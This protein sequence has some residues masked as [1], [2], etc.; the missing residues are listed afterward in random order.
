MRAV[1][2]EDRERLHA[3][4]RGLSPA[5]PRESWTPSGDGWVRCSTVQAAIALCLEAR[6]RS[7]DCAAWSREGQIPTRIP[8]TRVLLRRAAEVRR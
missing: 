3:V 2:R 1:W 8:E 6:R 4:A 7:I 5:S